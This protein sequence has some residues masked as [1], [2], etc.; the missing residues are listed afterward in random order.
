MVLLWLAI[1]TEQLVPE[2][3]LLFILIFL[4]LQITK[5]P[6]EYMWLHYNNN[7]ISIHKIIQFL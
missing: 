1:I 3:C 5:V 6:I 7:C 4:F 2:F